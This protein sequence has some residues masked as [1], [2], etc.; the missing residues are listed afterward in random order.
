MGT[1]TSKNKED[2]PSAA[3]TEI[4]LN[5]EKF[6]SNHKELVKFYDEELALL[7]NVPE[8]PPPLKI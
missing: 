1:T 7:K 4:R 5:M 2:R 6:C 8:E 3:A